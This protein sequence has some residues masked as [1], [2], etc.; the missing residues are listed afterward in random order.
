[1]NDNTTTNASHQLLPGSIIVALDWSELYVER[2][3]MRG[4]AAAHGIRVVDPQGQSSIRNTLIAGNE[5]TAERITIDD[6]G[7]G[8]TVTRIVDTT[9]ADNA[10]FSGSTINTAHD[11]TLLNS[12]V[13]EFA[14]STLHTTG[15]PEIT[16]SGILADDPTG[17]AG[18]PDVSAGA[19]TY[20]DA[21]N[22]DYHL[23]AVIQ[24]GIVAASAGIDW[25]PV[26][27]DDPV[28]LDGN[29]RNLDVPQVPDHLLSGAFRDIGC[30]EAQP[31][32]DRIF[33]DALGDPLSL[34][35]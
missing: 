28:D 11:L 32:P 23:R 8:A 33:G 20:V 1:V 24:D 27:T 5:F 7:N 30:Y 2:V 4:N 9:I 10:H 22:G 18:Q 6:D 14:M 34:L 31:I 12:I 15:T 26:S 3:T 25:E 35:Q 17:L 29:P 21:A 16:A 19:P 13:D